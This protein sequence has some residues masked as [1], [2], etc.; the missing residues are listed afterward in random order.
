M[1]SDTVALIQHT[2]AGDEAAFARLVS[3]YE[4]QIHAYALR[5]IGDFHIAED[6]TQETF[7]EVYQ[8]LKTLKDPEKF[9]TWLYAIVKNLCIA[10]YRKNRFQPESLEEIHISKIETDTYSRYVAT[11][12]AKATAYAQRDLVKKLLRT[13]KESDRE[14][15][16]LHYFDEMTTAEIETHLG[17]PENTIKS[18]LYRARQR[19]KKH[20]F[21][22][23]EELDITIQGKHS[24][25]QHLKGEISMADEVRN[26]SDVDARLEEMQRQITD[27]QEQIK[28][29]AAN[30][31]ASTEHTDVSNSDIEYRFV[32]DSDAS[33]DSD[34][35]QALDALLQLS[36]HVKDPITW[37]YAGAY[38]TAPG[39]R[40]SRGSVWT[41]NVDHF[42]SF[43]PDAEI[44]KLATFFTNP[45]VVSVLRQLVAGKK[46][47]TDLANGCGISESEMEKTVEMLVDGAL[48][49][50][51]EDDLIEPKNDAVFYF[52]NFVGM[53]TVYLNP[54]DYHNQD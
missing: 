42:L 22:I 43:A 31:D 9:S 17:I 5:E 41:T 40:S 48:V 20:E 29:I 6:I 45:T 52:L 50:R 39:Q 19:L 7:L 12:H 3:K 25:Q 30:S 32:A 18:R 35:K 44:V 49:K 47:V 13:L 46:S 53:V 14:I 27:L 16:T 1:K 26:E 28:G 10:W 15:I 38:Q 33:T 2:L 8:K 21:M 37:C 34:K 51:T 11:E 54:E 36:H 23:Q 4:K 24:S